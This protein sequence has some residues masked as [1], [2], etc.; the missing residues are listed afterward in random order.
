MAALH[1]LETTRE[2]KFI[3]TLV[4]VCVCV[5]ACGSDKP[6]VVGLP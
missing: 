2:S 1:F 4:Y 3:K 5:R 6:T